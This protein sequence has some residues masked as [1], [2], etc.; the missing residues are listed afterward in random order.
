MSTTVSYKGSTI[1]TVDDQTKILSTKGTW[2]EDDITIT[3]APSGN[4]V[5]VVDT[6]DSHGGTIRTITA[7]NVTTLQGQKSV[8]GSSKTQTI[9]PDTGYDGFASVVVDNR[10]DLT[11]PKDVDFIDFD[12]RL[13]YSYTAQ[14]FAALTAMP[15]NPSY[16]GLTAQGW[17]WTLADAKEYVAEWGALVIG[18][19]YTTD[20]GKTRIYITVNQD[21]VEQG[22]QF[23]IPFPSN[24]AYSVTV[25]WGDGTTPSTVTKT[26]TSWAQNWTPYHSYQSAGDYVIEITVNSGGGLYLG[27][28]GANSSIIDD[29]WFNFHLV[30]KV[31]VGNGFTAIGRQPFRN[32]INLK[33]VSM[34]ATCNS[35]DTGS[36]YAIFSGCINL[37]GF[38]FPSGI[39]GK[40]K[41]F[42]PDNMMFNLKY[43]AVPKSMTRF[44]MGT[45]M[46][47]LR[48][49]TLPPQSPTTNTTLNLHLYHSGVLTHLI[50]PGTY[51]TINDNTLNSSYIKKLTIPASVITIGGTSAF[52]S[53]PYLS[54]IHMLPTTP[55]TLSNSGSF[56][57]GPSNR[58]IYV[59]YSA[60]HSI[61]NAYK[62]ATNWATYADQMQEEPQS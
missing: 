20:D 59:P 32:M 40:D 42:F 5:V 18:Q 58:V 29:G 60:D 4:Q 2:L 49:L 44:Q 23:R 16:P 13:V 9:T 7:Q 1:A 35:I 38:V 37:K 41:C 14:E 3:D 43:V 39:V 50:I 22:R 24:I 46:L 25:D 17:N 6:P 21:Y 54:E 34:P 28:V 12:G 62:T 53:N 26:S 8:I 27:Y 61:L 15:A 55:P 51:V 47:N 30:T 48:K 11:A 31:E 56:G 19:N 33:S 10:D 36:D 52:G 45:Y 57:G